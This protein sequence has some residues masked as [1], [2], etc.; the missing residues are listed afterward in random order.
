MTSYNIMC[1][2]IT[3]VSVFKEAKL[4]LVYKTMSHLEQII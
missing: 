3:I 1:I 2:I 4:V